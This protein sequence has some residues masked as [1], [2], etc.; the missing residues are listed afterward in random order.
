MIIGIEQTQ[1]DDK[2][3]PMY[4]AVAFPDRVVDC[5]FPFSSPEDDLLIVGEDS[6]W[7]RH[8]KGSY[9]VLGKSEMID[10][11]VGTIESLVKNVRKRLPDMKKTPDER[12]R[13]FGCAGEFGSIPNKGLVLRFADLLRLEGEVAV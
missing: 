2:G 8:E 11:G 12:I 7:S 4:V 13:V 3:T 9:S 6:E 5:P 10:V 1:Y